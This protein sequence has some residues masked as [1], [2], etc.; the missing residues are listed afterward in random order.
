MILA[1]FSLLSNVVYRE[2]V[3]NKDG[4]LTLMY[5]AILMEILNLIGKQLL[6]IQSLKNQ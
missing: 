5:K 3:M 4:A 6:L 2:P 1:L